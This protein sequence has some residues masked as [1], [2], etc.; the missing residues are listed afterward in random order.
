[1]SGYNVG[2]VLSYSIIFVNQGLPG[3]VFSE[4]GHFSLLP[5]STHRGQRPNVD[6]VARASSL[7]PV[8][9]GKLPMLFCEVVNVQEER[10]PY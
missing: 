5:D 3:K 4:G 10:I 6:K 8:C 1:M 9:R 7:C 2:F